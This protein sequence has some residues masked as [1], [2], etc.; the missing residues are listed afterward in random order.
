[1]VYAEKMDFLLCCWYFCGSRVSTMFGR[2]TIIQF[3]VFGFHVCIKVRMIDSTTLK[4]GNKDEKVYKLIKR[5][6]RILYMV[7]L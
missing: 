1:L 7:K 3:I 6:E 2:S 5:V 4:F